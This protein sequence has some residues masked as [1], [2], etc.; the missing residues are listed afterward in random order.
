[1]FFQV[2]DLDGSERAGAQGPEGA[3]DKTVECIALSLELAH[4]LCLLPV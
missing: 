4:A 2:L 1:M 3:V